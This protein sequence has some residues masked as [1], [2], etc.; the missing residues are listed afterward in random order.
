MRE[1]SYRAFRD[2]RSRGSKESASRG[3][4]DATERSDRVESAPAAARSYGDPIGMRATS[5]RMLRKYRRLSLDVQG[6]RGRFVVR[7][8]GLVRIAGAGKS[9]PGVMRMNR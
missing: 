1:R 9:D 2:A 7:R 4:Q 3:R 8:R 6:R 5:P